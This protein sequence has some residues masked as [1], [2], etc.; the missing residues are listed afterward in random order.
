MLELES[1][2]WAELEHAYGDAGDTPDL[3]RAIAAERTPNYDE[4][5][6][7]YDVYSSLF[8]QRSTYSATYAA[9]PHIVRATLDGSRQQRTA[10]LLVAGQLRI[11]GNS[12]TMIPKDLL[13][14]FEAAMKSVESSSLE[15]LRD[16]W[17]EADV[18]QRGDLLQ[19]LG[20][21]RFPRNGYIAQLDVLTREAWSVEA[22]CPACKNIVE[23]QLGDGGSSTQ[24]SQSGQLIQ[25][26]TT[27]WQVMRDSYTK[28]IQSGRE[29]LRDLSRWDEDSTPFVLAALAEELGDVELPQKILDL[30][31]TVPCAY[32]GS[33]FVLCDALTPL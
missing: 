20:G 11:F 4:G 25:E 2:R 8:H 6:A 9:F 3:I 26:T 28:A 10:T 23:C 32:C 5:G 16:A 19:A 30:G 31:A 22:R 15:I 1:P 17:P 12:D 7:W 13:P 21:L 18:Y 33:S 24:I 27:R 29:L 14:D